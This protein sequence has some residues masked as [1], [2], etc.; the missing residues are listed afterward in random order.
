MAKKIRV[1]II[2]GGKSLEHEVSIRS[3][4][5]VFQL[6]DKKKYEPIA[7]GIDKVGTWYLCRP[8]FLLEQSDALVT[9]DQTNRNIIAKFDI[10]ELFA[11][12]IRNKIDVVFPVLHGAFGEDGSIQGLFKMAGIPFVGAGVL[13]S[14]IGMDKDLMKRLLRDADIPS[15]NFLCITEKKT[16]SFAAVVKSLGLP[17]FI[18]PANAGSSVGVFKITSAKEYNKNLTA[19]FKFDNKVLIEEFIE[20]REIEC[21]VLG[22]AEPIASVPGEVTTEHD[23]YSYDAKY[24]DANGTIPIIPAKIK[25]AVREKIRKVAIEAYKVLSCEGMARVDFFLRGD[26][27]I[28]NELNTIPGFTSISMYPKLWEASGISCTELIDRLIKLA[29]ERYATEQKLQSSYF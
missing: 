18:K 3:A 10:C 14:A 28:V 11:S 1:G 8:N 9:F 25:A 13:G 26:E 22:N 19:A 23:F 15:A 4:R 6:I 20:G 17:F 2:F 5:N 24:V 21:S 12:N 27:V 29:L 16:P 7:I